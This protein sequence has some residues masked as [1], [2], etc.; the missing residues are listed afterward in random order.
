MTDLKVA[1]DGTRLGSGGGLAHLIGILDMDD[2]SIYGIKE[3]HVWSHRKLLDAIPPRP[4][5]IKHHPPQAEQSVLTQLFWQ[6]TK[7]SSEIKAAGCQ[8]LFSVDAR[9]FCR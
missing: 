8:I 6:G 4:W 5:L 3:I 9:T 1:I 7:L 2:P